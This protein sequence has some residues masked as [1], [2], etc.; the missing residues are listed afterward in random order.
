[1]FDFLRRKEAVKG[2]D[3][4][5]VRACCKGRIGEVKA[6]IS[7]AGNEKLEYINILGYKFDNLSLK[8]AF[9]GNKEIIECQNKEKSEVGYICEYT[10]LIAAC[11]SGN[12]EL[13]EF[14]IKE[15]ADVN[16]SGCVY[17]MT[18]LIVATIKN[19]FNVVKELIHCNINS[20]GSFYKVSPLTMACMVG[21]VELVKLLIKYS[22]DVHKS[23]DFLVG[24][25]LAFACHKGYNEIA[26]LLINSKADI[27]KELC[28]FYDTALSIIS[29]DD[30]NK[31]NIRE[32]KKIEAL[33]IEKK[34]KISDKPEFVESPIQTARR[35]NN[36]E[37]FTFLSLKKE[38]A[39]NNE[40]QMV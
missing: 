18:P 22:A 13:V 19:N 15:G 8:A 33:L 17:K 38:K 7:K 32:Y 30:I 5:L 25:A 20:S 29:S 2:F 14:L 16:K 24:T 31:E 39:I 21:D 4:E 11:E 23:E 37:L 6:L 40:K 28:F 26:K 1:M 34:A 35:C 12:N 36:A 9:Y 10:P 27:N 3:I